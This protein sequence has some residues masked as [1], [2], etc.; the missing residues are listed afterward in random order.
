M[1][2]DAAAQPSNRT[3]GDDAT[4]FV[5]IVRFAEALPEMMIALIDA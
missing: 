5:P 2:I 1:L 3:Q 4:P